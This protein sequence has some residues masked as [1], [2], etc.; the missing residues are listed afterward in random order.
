VHL[1]RVVFGAF[2]DDVLK[3]TKKRAFWCGKM[4]KKRKLSPK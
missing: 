4:R 2:G 3:N 1:V